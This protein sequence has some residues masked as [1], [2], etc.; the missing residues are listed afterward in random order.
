MWSTYT[1]E[2]ANR[3][4]SMPSEQYNIMQLL[5]CACMGRHFDDS[6]RNIIAVVVV[7]ASSEEKYIS[8]YNV[9]VF[10]CTLRMLK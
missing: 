5:T 10:I 1:R 7:Y 6:H 3:L 2:C 8:I 4:I 9:V